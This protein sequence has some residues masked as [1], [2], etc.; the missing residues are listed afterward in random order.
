MSVFGQLTSPVLCST[1]SWWVTTIVGKP[2]STDQP[3]RPTQLFILLGSINRVPALIGWG[4]DGNVTSAGCQ[5]TLCDP[6]WHMSSVA[7]RRLRTAIRVY[8]TL[9]A[10]GAGWSTLAS[11]YSM[12]EVSHFCCTVIIW[13]HKRTHTAVRLHY[14]TTI[15]VGIMG[16][17][18]YCVRAIW[19]I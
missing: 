19:P 9:L 11:I 3:T 5:V 18:F 4:K 16:A 15:A 14:P 2:S 12:S 7:A 13:T 10:I 1:C 17:F 6:I 8:F